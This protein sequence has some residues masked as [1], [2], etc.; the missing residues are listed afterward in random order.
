MHNAHLLGQP[1]RVLARVAAA[2]Q[3]HEN[4]SWRCAAIRHRCHCACGSPQPKPACREQNQRDDHSDT[5]PRHVITRVFVLFN[6][7]HSRA[8]LCGSIRARA[9]DCV[10]RATT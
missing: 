2:M 10:D 4:A 9:R 1:V 7:L 3:E 8:R 5:D 6:A